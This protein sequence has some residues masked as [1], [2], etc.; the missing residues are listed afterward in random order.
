MAL[1]RPRWWDARTPG[2]WLWLPLAAI[3]LMVSTLRRQL[4]RR[5]F[6]R[7]VKLPVPVIVVG[8]LAA[9]GSGKTPVVI[10]LA[11][12]L[13]AH[14][15]QPGILSRGYGGAAL[16]PEAVLV[17]SDPELVGDEPV[18]LAR[19]TG[20]PL[21]IGR[22]RADAGRQLLEASPEVDILITDDGL[23]HYRLDRDVEIIVLNERILGNGW[24]MP[25]GPMREPLSRLADAVMVVANGSLSEGLLQTLPGPIPVSMQLVPGFFYRLE[26]TAERSAAAAFS[27]RRVHA[28][29]GIA[30][31]QRFFDSLRAMG[32]APVTSRA[33]GDHHAFCKEDLAVPEGDVLLLTEKDAVKCAALAPA[34]CWVLPVDAQMDDAALKP[35]LERLHG[36]QVA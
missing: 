36:S 25:A 22:D 33:F 4:Y 9:G 13:R 30:D 26:N 27:G 35:I 21:W 5:G 23:Q 15:F 16:I 32:L 14:G 6:F 2:A 7:R 19:R 12:A 1:K 11:S 28:L 17:D 31:P 24:P 8:N 29:A 3:F 34:D 10:W 20:C 18:M